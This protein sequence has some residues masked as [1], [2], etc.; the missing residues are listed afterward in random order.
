MPYICYYSKRYLDTG[1]AHIIGKSREVTARTKDGTL[2]ICELKLNEIRVSGSER[3]FIGMLH[4]ITDQK[5]LFETVEQIFE[6]GSTPMILINEVGIMQKFNLSASATFGYSKE[7]AIGQNIKLLM[8]PEVAAHHDEYIKRYVDTGVA[9]II[10]KSREVLA[11]TKDG[12]GLLCELKL[13]EI[14]VNCT[15]RYFVGLLHDITELKRLLGTV[16]QIF[17]RGSAPMIVINGKGIVQRWNECA[18]E[19]FGYTTEEMIGQNISVL[20]P[21]EYAEKHDYYLQRYEE[22]GIKTV[23]GKSRQL[24]ALKKDGTRL[25]CE[26]KL[27]ELEVAGERAYIGILHDVTEFRRKV[28]T[29]TVL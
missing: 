15:G 25:T 27:N 2:V 29:L 24:P 6:K 13:N 4:D 10:G 11:R 12:R 19:T 14:R 3:Y 20:M 5:R 7:E 28:Q 17:E 18:A 1:V 22:T 8:P 9:R 21:P 26:L 16:E 23:M